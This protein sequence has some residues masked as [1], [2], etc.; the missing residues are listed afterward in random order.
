MA[1]TWERIIEE[2]PNFAPAYPPLTRLYDTDY[3]YSGLGS[4]GEAERRRAYEL[5]HRAFALD[6]TESHFHAMKG[7]SHMLA[8]EW[9]RP[10]PHLAEP[11]GVTPSNQR[12]PVKV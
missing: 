1:A 8:G 3:C 11:L 4:T 5:A 10:A 12:R 9:A 7:W 6:R 2:H